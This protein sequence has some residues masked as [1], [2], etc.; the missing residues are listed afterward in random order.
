[1]GAARRV[2]RGGA[3]WTGSAAAPL[4]LSLT[5]PAAPRTA[6]GG[7]LGSYALAIH[8]G[9]CMIDQQKMRARIM[10]LQAR[11]AAGGVHVERRS[12]AG[13]V[14]VTPQLPARS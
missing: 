8:C 11:L 6:E 2:S 12:R 1:M 13:L 7:G 9:G 10:D 3:H 14:P 5:L 4:P